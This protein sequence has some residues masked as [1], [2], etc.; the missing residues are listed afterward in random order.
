MLP[1]TTADYYYAA[2]HSETLEF[3][4]ETALA[5]GFQELEGLLTRI[6][7]SFMSMLGKL[8][9][10]VVYNEEIIFRDAGQ[11]LTPQNFSG[12]GG[13]TETIATWGLP[14]ISLLSDA[15][16]IFRTVKN[17]SKSL[18]V[19]ASSIR[20]DLVSKPAF[21]A[22]K[23]NDGP[24]L[25]GGATGFA[26]DGFALA[27]LWFSLRKPELRGQRALF[28]SILEPRTQAAIADQVSQWRKNFRQSWT[29]KSPREQARILE[30]I[31]KFEKRLR[32]MV[33]TTDTHLDDM[34]TRLAW[35]LID[36]I[37]SKIAASGP[38]A[39]S[40]ALSIASLRLSKTGHSVGIGQ[41]VSW[42]LMGLNSI[43]DENISKKQKIAAQ[44]ISLNDTASS[45]TIMTIMRQLEQL[46]SDAN[47]IFI[48]GSSVVDYDEDI[49]V[50]PSPTVYDDDGLY[51]P[52]TITNNSDE[53]V[54]VFLDWAR[55]MSLDKASFWAKYPQITEGLDD[56]QIP[57]VTS[58]FRGR[59]FSIGSSRGSYTQYEAIGAHS[60]ATIY[61]VHHEKDV[62]DSVPEVLRN[63]T[64]PTDS[65]GRRLSRGQV[66]L[67]IGQSTGGDLKH[68]FDLGVG[69]EDLVDISWTEPSSARLS[70]GP[71][72]RVAALTA[73][74]GKAD[75]LSVERE[76]WPS[77]AGGPI[78]TI[79]VTNNGP[80]SVGF[81]WTQLMPSGL[82]AI[83]EDDRISLGSSGISGSMILGPTETTLLQAR[84]FGSGD[85]DQI[86][87]GELAVTA[88]DGSRQ[89]LAAEEFPVS[90]L[91]PRIAIDARA[92]FQAFPGDTVKIAVS[93]ESHVN[94]AQDI[95]LE[96]HEI[97][98]DGESVLESQSLQLSPQASMESAFE[99]VADDSDT[100][101]RQFVIR[102]VD[103]EVVTI[104][105]D[106]S[107]VLI[108][109]DAD[110][111]GLEDAWETQY[112]LDTASDDSGLDADTDGLTNLEE[113]LQ[114]TN[115]LIPDTDLDGLKDGA[116]VDLGT[117]PLIADSDGG[118]E[119]DGAETAAGRNPLE[120]LDDL[121]SPSL[122]L[123]SLV[124]GSQ[125]RIRVGWTTSR[126][127]D[128][129]DQ[130]LVAIGTEPDSA[131]VYDWNLLSPR[132]T[133]TFSDLDL[134]S[135]QTYYVTY[136]ESWNDNSQFASQSLPITVNDIPEPEISVDGNAVTV[137][138]TGDDG[139]YLLYGGDFPGEWE[140]LDRVEIIDGHGS[141]ETTSDQQRAFY[142][143]IHSF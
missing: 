134:T 74:P 10:T 53:S 24:G 16:E 60:S 63:V 130:M 82:E 73:E 107:S 27:D 51:T 81:D 114:F 106:S 36:V 25:A 22:F 136:A 61:I 64:L 87:L 47:S 30:F 65:E 4:W 9:D 90:N 40:F 68:I 19:F 49:V 76:F 133:F 93:L 78:L 112:W 113:Q 105:S 135:G 110:A 43:A 48:D 45:S 124:V 122:F 83:I 7:E 104:A 67:S 34:T 80:T 108:L 96:W 92:P 56:R 3:R 97:T 141:Y 120:P 8:K 143:I 62:D 58:S 84:V 2:E 139:E 91:F 14:T 119:L 71:D 59:S 20:N 31:A 26:L 70:A 44:M 28:E 140:L 37:G 115:P 116:E 17:S 46:L 32:H 94:E 69:T 12:F 50:T 137:L 126:Q 52:I 89:T 41:L 102:A 5:T 11:G 29:T 109:K 75:F 128:L 127:I 88:D 33:L 23:W 35:A 123:P 54:N 1:W 55:F 132:S 101:L 100:T 118:G 77:N 57:I 39:S 131:D 98:D 95:T 86:S 42:A 6:E 138:L 13:G 21:E 18:K 121:S 129:L 85:T 125:D 111:D 142:Q 117:D 103:S 72:F 66:K 99:F 38:R 15:P 79:R